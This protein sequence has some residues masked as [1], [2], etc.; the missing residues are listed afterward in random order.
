MIFPMAIIIPSHF[1]LPKDCILEVNEKDCSIRHIPNLNPQKDSP[2]LHMPLIVYIYI[3]F[4]E[5][6]HFQNNITITH[7][8]STCHRYFELG[9]K[10]YKLSRHGTRPN[11]NHGANKETIENI[12]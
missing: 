7:Q 8:P 11:S 10:Q 12:I 9:S 4:E 1:N 6:C 2:H 3:Y 5:E